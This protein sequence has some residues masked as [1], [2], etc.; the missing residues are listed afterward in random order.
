[1]FPIQKQLNCTSLSIFLN[2]LFPHLV[3]PFL[4]LFLLMEFE[5]RYFLLP[6]NAFLLLTLILNLFFFFFPFL[7]GA[8]QILPSPL[9]QGAVLYLMTGAG[10]LWRI[11]PGTLASTFQETRRFLFR[12]ARK[13][14]AGSASLTVPAFNAPGRRHALT[15]LLFFSVPPPT[16]KLRSS[17]FF[18]LI[19]WG[20]RKLPPVIFPLCRGRTLKTSA[21]ESFFFLCASSIGSHCKA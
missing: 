11:F 12:S 21:D 19:F 6:L 16:L 15:L 9:T 13:V 1:M 20:G 8:S 17:Q 10:I 2:G 7:C 14:Y 3:P 4:Y 18:F 5:D